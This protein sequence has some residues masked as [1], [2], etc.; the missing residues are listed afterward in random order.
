MGGC[1]GVRVWGWWW[2]GPQVSFIAFPNGKAGARRP[3]PL[4]HMQ[5]FR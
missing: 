4:T 1:W 5:I 3:A 2:A